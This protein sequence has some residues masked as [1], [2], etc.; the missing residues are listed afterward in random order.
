M[1]YQQPG[2][3]TNEYERLRRMAL[4][5]ASEGRAGYGLFL[6]RGMVVWMR[7]WAVCRVSSSASPVHEIP[8]AVEADLVQ[9]LTAMIL[10]TYL[11]KKCYGKRFISY[12]PAKNHG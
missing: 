7:T 3:L 8:A 6:L 9:V 4:S 5:R 1:A 10:S 2:S 12:G 11:D